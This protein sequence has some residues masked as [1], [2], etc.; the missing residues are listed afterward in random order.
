MSLLNL[1]LTLPIYETSML[2]I[3]SFSNPVIDVLAIGWMIIGKSRVRVF[4]S[5]LLTLNSRN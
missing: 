5:F 2:L 4:L 3:L 1:T